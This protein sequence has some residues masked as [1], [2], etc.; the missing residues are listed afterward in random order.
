MKKYLKSVVY[1][2]LVIMLVLSVNAGSYDDVLKGA[3]F[4][5]FK[6]Y[7]GDEIG[8]YQMRGFTASADGKF[9][10][11]GCLQGDKR[12]YK[13]DAATGAILG[14]Y[15]DTKE[16]GYSKG[17][18]TDDRGYLYVGIS[19]NANDG[20]VLFSIVDYNT[21][22]EVYIE[23]ISIEGKVGVNGAAVHKSGDKYILYFVTNYGPN[24][25][26]SYDV[27]DVKKPALNTA[28]G[29]GGKISI[30]AVCGAD[31]EGNYIGVDASDNIYLSAKTGTGSKG[32][33]L[34]KLSADGKNV[35]A[36][37]ALSE[38]Y[39]VSI[40]DEYVLVSTYAGADSSVFVLNTSD[41]SQVAELCK[42]GD[43]T[44][45]SMAIFGGDKIYVSDHGFGGSGDRIFVSGTLNIPVKQVAAEPAPEPESEPE[46]KAEAEAEAA[47]VADT[48]VKPANNP[49]T[50]D[51]TGMIAAIMILAAVAFI[52]VK[53]SRKA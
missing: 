43:A 52:L 5:E 1:I 48:A 33:T 44:N 2:T 3:S 50:G 9:L 6:V 37:I 22:K 49:T 8:A 21:M 18:A 36:K 16:A 53:K 15:I 30:Q 32:D 28:F 42:P 12:V 39:G 35:L 47:A 10:F 38:A 23:Q 13:F 26:Y 7:T 46:I 34:F 20:A 27:T 41:L 29:D 4:S 14:E 31:S 17:L 24:F 25:I 19:N 45:Y 40:K 51:G 11:G